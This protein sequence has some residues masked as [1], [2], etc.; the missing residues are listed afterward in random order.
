MKSTVRTSL[1]PALALATVL[2][3]G[4]MLL[5]FLGVGWLGHVAMQVLG[6][7][8]PREQLV[9]S[10]QGEPLV[11]STRYGTGAMTVYR[12]LDGQAIENLDKVELQRGSSWLVPPGI[13][14]Y[15]SYG[16]STR[17]LGFPDPSGAPTYWY[18]IAPESPPTHAYFVG[19]DAKTK[20]RFGYLGRAGFRSDPPPRDQQFAI[21]PRDLLAW[22]LV[23]GQGHTQGEEP[24]QNYYWKGQPKAVFLNSEGK[25]LR[26]DLRHRS[27]ATVPLDGKV[28]SLGNLYEPVRTSA[29]DAATQKTRIGALLADRVAIMDDAGQTLR[30]L[31]VPVAARSRVLNVFLTTGD[32]T[33]IVAIPDARHALT[34]A[35]WLDAQGMVVRHEQLALVGSGISGEAESPWLIGALLP[36]PLVSAV[37]MGFV[38]PRRL[39]AVGR[40]DDFSHALAA[41]LALSWPA[42]ASIMALSAT[43]AVITYRR[44]RRYR[45]EGALAWATFVLLLGPAGYV[46]YLVHRHWPARE[47]CGQCQ[48]SVPV[49]RAECLA[50]DADFPLPAPRGI[51]IY[52]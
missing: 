42:F 10:E 32:T 39:V 35:Y 11:E 38:T 7:T 51:E 15:E 6:G 40:Y 44:H 43:F 27:I 25:L 13:T 45:R 41:S 18:L 22:G 31:P 5:W 14:V 16:W 20:N 48:R 24:S 47:V 30:T 17:I 2:T 23:A 9:F 37:N 33:I 21:A 8:A 34:D 19:F 36:S 28:V 4:V 50:C 26:I 52:A 46:G 49:D 29:D 12:T 3:A 1:L